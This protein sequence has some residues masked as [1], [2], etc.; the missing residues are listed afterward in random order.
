M[1]KTLVL[2]LCA[3]M[4]LT[5]CGGGASSGDNQAKGDSKQKLVLSTFG[6][7]EDLS[8]EE[9][10]APFEQEFNCEIVT[11]TGGANDRYTKQMC[12]RDR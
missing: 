3:T 6:L 7:S 12:I 4:A 8:A 2:A 5:A 11:E 10:Y 9:V 1:K